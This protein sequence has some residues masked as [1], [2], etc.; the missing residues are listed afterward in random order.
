[1]KRITLPID[2]K[3]VES[4]ECGEM[5]SLN[6]VIYTARDAAHQRLI[7]CINNNDKD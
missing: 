3:T 5:I 6:G 2:N 1:M 4:L 7:N